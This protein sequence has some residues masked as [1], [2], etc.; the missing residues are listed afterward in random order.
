MVIC[1]S[2]WKLFAAAGGYPMSDFIIK[3]Q[4]MHVPSGQIGISWTGQAGF[5]FKDPSGLVYHIDPY[6]SNICSKYIGYHRA[7][8]APVEAKDVEADFLF[9]THEHRDHLDPESVPIIA[10]ANPNAILVGPPACISVLLELGIASERLITLKRG[11][12]KK[13]G[14]AL[15]GATLAYHTDDSIGYVLNFGEV[16]VYI[17]GDTTYSD[18]L[19]SVA[20]SKPDV[21]IPCIN[22]RLGCMN[23][24]DAA[25]LTAHI[26]PRV[27]VPMHHDMF[28]ENTANPHEFVRQAEAYSGITKGFIMRHGSWYLYSK[29][30]GFR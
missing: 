30:Q 3:Q 13:I 19:I 10:G 24:P 11:Q 7:I 28:I 21:M 2:K 22:G 23:I 26:Q 27:A 29:E 18:D 17:T 25:R 9:F 5:A 1:L 12:E 8:P 15:V 6:L 4:K 20:D 16:K 14:N